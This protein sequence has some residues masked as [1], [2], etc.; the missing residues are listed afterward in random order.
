VPLGLWFKTD[1]K[2]WTEDRIFDQNHDFFRRKQT[3]KI[4]AEHLSGK[5]DNAHK[6][7]L[8]LIFNEWSN[9]MHAM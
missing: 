9:L 4:W 1:L 5:A 6:I 2:T 7:W 8:L 3:E